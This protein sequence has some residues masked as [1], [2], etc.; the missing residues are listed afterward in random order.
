MRLALIP[1]FA[2]VSLV[3]SCIP[4]PSPKQ[5]E[6]VIILK[7]LRARLDPNWI[8]L[9]HVPNGQ[10]ASV[11][12]AVLTDEQGTSKDDKSIVLFGVCDVSGHDGLTVFQSLTSA[13]EKKDE[14]KVGEWVVNSAVERKQDGYALL[15]DGFKYVEEDRC[16]LWVRR[17]RR[18]D[19]ATYKLEESDLKEVSTLI[20]RVDLIGQGRQ[21]GT[22]EAGAE[23]SGE[24]SS[25]PS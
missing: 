1:A 23:R 11:V 7:H 6:S 24:P 13:H 20:E 4:A 19:T 8:I 22:G 17:G 9:T 18:I 16:Y 2:L 10:Y 21:A 12:S 3:C 5:R 25:R 14:R 15:I